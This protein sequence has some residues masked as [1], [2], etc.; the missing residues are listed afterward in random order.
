MAFR[1]IR[2]AIKA[3][4]YE[5]QLFSVLI[6]LAIALFML[7]RTAQA[8]VDIDHPRS[9]SKVV[10]KR[11]TTIIE[12]DEDVDDDQDE[13]SSRDRDKDKDE[14]ELKATFGSKSGTGMS[15]C[16]TE[17]L[18]AKAVK[19][20]K[21]D[22]NAWLKDRQAEL[23]SKYLVGTCDEECDDCGMHLKRCAVEGKVRY[24]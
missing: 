7:T 24:R 12:K 15:G 14:R 6:L 10:R 18:A 11:T 22:C 3:P 21:S 23:K 17:E 16:K 9:K 5:L 8:E 2:S 19:A 4:G 13:D 1:S 20:L